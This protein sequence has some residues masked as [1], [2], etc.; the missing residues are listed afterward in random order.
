M[1]RKPDR[2]S[3]R[4]ALGAGVSVINFTF[5]SAYPQVIWQATLVTLEL[6]VVTSLGG[7]V[8]GLLVA[9]VRT[10]GGRV[11]SAMLGLMIDFIRGTPV[12]VQLLIW[13]L[14][15]TLIGA[16]WLP[17][18]AAVVALSVNAGAFMSEIIRAGIRSLPIGQHEA[19]LAVGL[20]RRYSLLAIEIPQ[21][22]PL[23]LPA[24]VSFVIGLIKDTS[25]AYVVGLHELLRSAQL[26]ADYERR[27][28]EIYL[29]IGVIYFAICFPLSR[30]AAILENRMRRAGNIQVRLSI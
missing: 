4:L 6:S 12:L 1:D 20:S 7:L 22:M 26:V 30:I 16:N 17:F 23:V 8:L 2:I 15:P 21:A 10:L 25:I 28:L 18:T 5:L 11:V 24:M 9:V 13:Y 3:C 19:A 14:A 29:V 27:P